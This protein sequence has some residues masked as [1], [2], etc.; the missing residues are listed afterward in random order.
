MDPTPSIQPEPSTRTLDT[1]IRLM[2]IFECL[3]Y[4]Y[5]EHIIDDDQ[6]LK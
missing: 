1:G 3:P 4:L 2:N 5:A 6:T